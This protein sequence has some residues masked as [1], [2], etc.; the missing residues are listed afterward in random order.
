MHPGGP[1]K[2]KNARSLATLQEGAAGKLIRPTERS[3]HLNV[4]THT[5]DHTT[6]VHLQR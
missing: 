3:G 1:G 5:L 4:I 6:Q 2:L